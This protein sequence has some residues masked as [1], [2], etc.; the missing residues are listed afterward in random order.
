MRRVL[1]PSLS[2]L[3]HPPSPSARVGNGTLEEASRLFLKPMLAA[4]A[5]LTLGADYS[6]LFGS[7]V[8]DE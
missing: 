2:A 5:Q 6:L 3:S 8:V 1:L 4:G 7:P